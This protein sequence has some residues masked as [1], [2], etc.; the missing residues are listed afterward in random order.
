MNPALLEMPT[1]MSQP[2]EAGSLGALDA[3]AS[4][5]TRVIKRTDESLLRQMTENLDKK[6][7]SVLAC[8]TSEEFGKTRREIWERYFRARRALGDTIN[9]VIPKK[10]VESVRCA[11]LQRITEDLDR[12]RNV[13]FGEDIAQQFEFTMWTVNRIQ[14][15]AHEIAKAGEP[16]DRNADSRLHEDFCLYT[17]WGQFHYDCVL[18]SMKFEQPIHDDLQF[19]I[20]D[21]LRAWVNAAAIVEEALSLRV[22]DGIG[23][24]VQFFDQSWDD[25]DEELL[26]SSMKDLD[27]EQP[28]DV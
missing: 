19:P 7:L 23:G 8:R 26:A 4:G 13:L 11:T 24:T 12:S 1:R 28:S 6:L 27:A 16:S 21:G 20:R 14:A 9:L 5:E 3:T 25:E 17:A 22:P 2:F 15:V 10:F 18:A